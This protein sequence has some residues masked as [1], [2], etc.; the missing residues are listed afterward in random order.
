MPLLSHP[1]S[2]LTRSTTKGDEDHARQWFASADDDT[3]AVLREVYV[4]RQTFEDLGEPDTITVSI[5][6]G[7]TL[8]A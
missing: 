7:G 8:N 4:D 1:R 3:S 2:V 6:P 5:E